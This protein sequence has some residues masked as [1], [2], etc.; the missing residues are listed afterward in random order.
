MSANLPSDFPRREN[1]PISN[2]LFCVTKCPHV[3]EMP[4]C[5]SRLTRLWE[6]DLPALRPN[7]SVVRSELQHFRCFP[8][9]KRGKP[10]CCLSVKKVCLGV[11]SNTNSIHLPYPSGLNDEE[12]RVPWTWLKEHGRQ[13]LHDLHTNQFQCCLAARYPIKPRLGSNI[14]PIF[15]YFPIHFTLRQVLE[16]QT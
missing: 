5:Q 4:L 8:D 14:T 13:R 6:L 16:M 7:Y 11:T 9:Q 2:P 12:Q 3:W 1:G 10:M 15:D